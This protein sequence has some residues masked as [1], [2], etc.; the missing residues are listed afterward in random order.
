MNCE[1]NSYIIMENMVTGA[2]FIWKL[3]LSVIL[4]NR[5]RKTHR[6]VPLI[7]LSKSSHPVYIHNSGYH[8][9]TREQDEHQ[10]N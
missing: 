8:L 10:H 5:I 9:I 1:Q 3:A 6:Y 2:S 4:M 7:I